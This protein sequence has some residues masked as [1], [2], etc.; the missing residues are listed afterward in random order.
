MTEELVLIG[1]QES[2][3]GNGADQSLG[4]WRSDSLEHRSV[5]DTKGLIIQSQ[6]TAGRGQRL[7]NCRGN[8]RIT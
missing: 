3:S 5:W 2:G 1:E 8:G 7:G 6:E 4:S